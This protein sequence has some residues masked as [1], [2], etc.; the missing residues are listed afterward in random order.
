MTSVMYDTRMVS[1]AKAFGDAQS[2][3]AEADKDF[4]SIY[5]EKLEDSSKWAGDTNLV[6]R[7]THEVVKEYLCMVMGLNDKIRIALGGLCDGAESI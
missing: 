3:L 4:V 5:K 1:V 7:D 2:I 6:C